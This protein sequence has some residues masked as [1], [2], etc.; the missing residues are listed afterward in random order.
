VQNLGAGPPAP[1]PRA[2]CVFD[3]VSAFMLVAVCLYAG[4]CLPVCRWLS[5]C[6]PVAVCLYAG[7]CLP[8]CRWLSACMP[9]AVCAA[10][11]CGGVWQT[12]LSA[13]LFLGGG[14]AAEVY[15]FQPHT[16]CQ[17]RLFALLCIVHVCCRCCFSSGTLSGGQKSRVSFALISW[18]RP[19]LTV[20]D[21]PTNHLDIG[22]CARGDVCPLCTHAAPPPPSPPAPPSCFGHVPTDVPHLYTPLPCPRRGG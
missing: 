17:L 13:A 14:G 12:R 7:G 11:R 2:L 10:T 15:T 6:M 8:V 16:F 1:P 4:G 19:H 3:C 9:V 5:A 20:L 18:R 22:A 21:E